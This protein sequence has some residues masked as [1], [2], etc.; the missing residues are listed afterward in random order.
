MSWAEAIKVN[1]DMST[2]LNTASYQNFYD[3]AVIANGGYG[4]KTTG[5]LI[6][7]EYA[8]EMSTGAYA[9]STAKVAI[10]PRNVR[11]IGT[12]AF[13]QC[14]D[15]QYVVIPYGVEAISG[16]AFRKC[17]SLKSL[18]LPASVRSID[19]LA[20]DTYLEHLFVPWSEGT[21]SGAPWGATN[22]VIHYNAR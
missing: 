19:S 10:L 21:V 6:V 12:L 4:D 16:H 1:N 8:F 5:T 13:N 2:P 20:F 7:P 11:T 9:N 3:M 14:T 15:L 18:R 17:E 22:A